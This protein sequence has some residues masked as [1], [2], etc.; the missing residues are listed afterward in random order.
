[1][2]LL[3]PVTEVEGLQ[4][5]CGDPAELSCPPGP[6]KGLKDTQGWLIP[7]LCDCPSSA[8]LSQS[9]WELESSPVPLKDQLPSFHAPV[10]LCVSHG[11]VAIGA[12]LHGCVTGQ[13]WHC[14]LTAPVLGLAAGRIGASKVLDNQRK[15]GRDPKGH[16]G[17]SGPVQRP[18][19][20][21]RCTAGSPRGARK[22]SP[23][24]PH[25]FMSLHHVPSNPSTSSPILSCCRKSP[26]NTNPAHIRNCRA[27]QLQHCQL[28]ANIPI[29]PCQGPELPWKPLSSLGSRGGIPHAHPREGSGG[30]GTSGW[31][32]TPISALTMALPAAPRGRE[33]PGIIQVGKD[34]QDLQG[35]ALMAHGGTESPNPMRATQCLHLRDSATF[36]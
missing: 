8:K 31:V 15:V 25:I 13:G 9:W 3:L 24:F 11:A 12:G 34:L 18:H 33:A 23:Q 7:W 29:L 14:H 1:M 21:S 32:W 16:S 5:H 35:G 19:L 30:E 26:D 20:Q 17:H 10:A 28:A 27:R 36:I 6:R 4:S 2:E 22:G